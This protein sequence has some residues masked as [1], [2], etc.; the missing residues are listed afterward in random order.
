MTSSFVK[1]SHRRVSVELTSGSI[2][3]QISTRGTYRYWHFGQQA[4]LD[5][6]RGPPAF[7]GASHADVNMSPENII[8][9]ENISANQG[10]VLQA[11]IS[12]RCL[13]N[14]DDYTVLRD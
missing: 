9:E 7:S 6:D 4:I 11:N 5:L 1:E 13:L 12:A 2:G 3:T 8:I 14:M 10:H